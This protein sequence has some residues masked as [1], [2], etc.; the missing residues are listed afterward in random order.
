[1]STHPCPSN[2]KSGGPAAGRFDPLS[3]NIAALLPASSDAA[4]RRSDA[5]SRLISAAAEV[6]PE[7]GRALAVLHSEAAALHRLRAA[8]GLPAFTLAAACAR[9]QRMERGGTYGAALEAAASF[10]HVPGV[11]EALRAIAEEA[12]GRAA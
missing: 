3:A 6:N 1:M 4:F 11:A 12:A 10:S 5:I 7:A 2:A 9:E 8:E